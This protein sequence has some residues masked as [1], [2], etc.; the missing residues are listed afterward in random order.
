METQIIL[1]LAF[2]MNFKLNLIFKRHFCLLFVDNNI[3][4]HHD[5]NIKEREKN[6]FWAKPS[7]L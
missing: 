2:F 5:L 4:S 1:W 3:L 7:L 6:T